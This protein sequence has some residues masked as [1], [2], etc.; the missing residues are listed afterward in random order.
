MDNTNGETHL[1]DAHEE[2]IKE[3]YEEVGI[4]YHVS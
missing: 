1:V 4:C 2:Q 3:D